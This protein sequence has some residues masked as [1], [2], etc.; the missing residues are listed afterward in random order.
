M[1]ASKTDFSISVKSHARANQDQGCEP[2]PK[3]RKEQCRQRN[4]ENIRCET[5]CPIDVGEL[6]GF[7]SGCT[8][9]E[10]S[11]SATPRFGQQPWNPDAI[12]GLGWLHRIV[13][14]SQTHPKNKCQ[15][16]VICQAASK[17][18]DANRTA[19]PKNTLRH[20]IEDQAEGSVMSTG[21]GQK[22]RATTRANKTKVAAELKPVP[23]RNHWPK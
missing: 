2:N 6:V 10:R 3:H 11:V 16:L 9:G 22:A 1:S 18:P 15:L 21:N 4:N 19:Y 7:H 14:D 5:G 13:G 20:R 12:A 23:L 8:D 17:T